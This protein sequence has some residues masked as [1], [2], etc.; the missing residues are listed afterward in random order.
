MK[1]IILTLK[2]FGPY[3]NERI[4][5]T[6]LD[7]NELF[8]ISG[9]T[10]SGK[11]M[12]L[13]GI[14]YA[15]YGKASGEN[16]E[17]N[18]FVS[19]YFGLDDLTEVFMEFEIKDKK[20]S[21][22]RV[23]RQERKKK[24]GEGTTV[25]NSIAELQEIGKDTKLYTKIETV[26]E[27]V[28]ELIGLNHKQFIQIMMMP[29]GE[30]RKF[31]VAD[32]KDKEDILK[33]LFNTDIYSKLQRHT[34]DEERKMKL[35]LSSQLDILR[36]DVS[37]NEYID[38][39]EMKPILNDTKDNYHIIFPK[40]QELIKKDTETVKNFGKEKKS[41]EKNIKEQENKIEKA[42]KINE[43][44]DKKQKFKN[45]L[46]QEL[47]KDKDIKD[48][49]KKAK[50]ARKSLEIKPLEKYYIKSKN[51]LKELKAS[52]KET[53]EVL[54]KVVNGY[55]LLKEKSKEY[56]SKEYEKNIDKLKESI[57]EWTKV[58]PQI[59]EKEKLEKI[60]ESE[61]KEIKSL[62]ET[63][64]K[65]EKDLVENKERIKEFFKEIKDISDLRLKYKESTDK[66]EEL[67]LYYKKLNDIEKNRKKEEELKK[68]AEKLEKEKQNLITKIQKAEKNLADHKK[69]YFSNIGAILAEQLKVG[70]PCP[71]C[72]SIVHEK[73]SNL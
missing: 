62:E 38:H 29:Q 47:K 26:N 39:E 1:N 48:K 67:K 60:L 54:T 72:S 18:D 8:L 20:Y 42:K 35:N 52:L 7:D 13:D 46:K 21:I 43:K 44:L 71:V 49:T 9:P 40:I 32:S 11:T 33:K 56:E 10:G 57:N 61:E 12:I 14:S 64:E 27:R 16:R 31:L 63:T 24:L 17:D 51:E 58:L 69:R 50:L 41:I 25:Q 5:F 28:N 4:D 68:G 15:L 6:E 3:K 70:Q 65:R 30:F 55:D 73:K 34:L 2:N 22:R 45:D 59:D 23:P 37:N 66:R 19:D 36:H 53:N